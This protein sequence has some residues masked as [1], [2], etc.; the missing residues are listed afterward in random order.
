MAT[1]EG[2][3]EGREEGGGREMEGGNERRASGRAMHPAAA[4]NLNSES[5]PAA[6]SSTAPA[7]FLP[8]SRHCGSIERRAY[9]KGFPGRLGSAQQ[10]CVL[11][12][13][14]RTLCVP[15]AGLSPKTQT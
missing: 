12:A 2:G 7:S 13:V 6:L 1:N 8:S 5:R 15:A 11:L 9:F 10:V 3:K 14:C 4:A